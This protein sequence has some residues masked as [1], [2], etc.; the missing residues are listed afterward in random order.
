MAKLDLDVLPIPAR[1]RD[2]E[3]PRLDKPYLWRDFTLFALVHILPLGALFTGTKW[4]DWAVCVGLYWLRMFAVT[5]GYH[6]YFSHR[7]FKT[8]RVFQFLLAFLAETSSQKGALWWAAHHR[9]HHK[10]SDT[11]W[12]A[13]SP[14]RHGFW[15]SHVL[16][17]YYPDNDPTDYKQVRDLARYPELVWLNEHWMVPV[18]VLGAL[19]LLTMG[20]SGFFIAFALSTV[21]LW[22]GTFTINSLS[23]VYGS[24]RF[25]TTDTSRNNWLLALITMGEGWHNNHHHYMLST[26][27]G[28]RWYEID[29]TFYILKVMSWFHLVW[30]LRE[31]PAELMR[32]S[33][34]AAKAADEPA[35]EVVAAP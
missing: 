21:L 5:G 12:D 17:V 34:P 20:W 14:I 2:K 8:G 13:H 4:Q 22:H 32:A 9:K 35:P 15:H 16:W 7:T 31:P 1:L 26:R 10:Y 25:A 19:I 28:F 6:R 30:D 33:A 3:P 18:I 24:R 29:L 23:H 27:Q 11:P